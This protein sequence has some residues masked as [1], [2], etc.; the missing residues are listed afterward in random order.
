[1][2]ML[3]FIYSTS[4][5]HLGSFHFVVIMNN[6]AKN[7]VVLV[8]GGHMYKFSKSTFAQSNAFIL[9]F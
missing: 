7:I 3:Q 6:A 2:N 4:A 1:M 9:N 8:S 5:G